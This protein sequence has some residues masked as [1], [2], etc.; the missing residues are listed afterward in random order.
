MCAADASLD[1]FKTQITWRIVVIKHEFVKTTL[2]N[3][4]TMS[5]EIANLPPPQGAKTKH[6]RHRKHMEV[7]VS[8]E[9]ALS[10]LSAAG[11][12]IA[13]QI[14]KDSPHGMHSK[15]AK[16]FF[17][18]YTRNHEL[19][20]GA[21]EMV[22]RANKLVRETGVRLGYRGVMDMTTRLASKLLNL[23]VW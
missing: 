18:A 20:L 13:V 4:Q 6:L 17:H 7:Q 5:Q 11:A 21:Q 16:F 12:V 2:Q 3:M 10:Q 22:N 9:R 23:M 8:C 14:Q 1:T 15:E 19:V